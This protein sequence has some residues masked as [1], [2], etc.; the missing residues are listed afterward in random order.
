[1]I[2]PMVGR[3]MAAGL[4]AAA[5]VV[6]APAAN[7][8]ACAEPKQMD[9]FKTCADVA[10]AEAEGAF[11]LYT[12]DPEAGSAKLM[13]SFNQAFPRSRPASSACKPARSSP[14]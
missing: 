8:A 5:I 12:T 13:A 11:V 14:S 7:A 3:V 10:K 9:G 4:A 6:L 1:M 2:R